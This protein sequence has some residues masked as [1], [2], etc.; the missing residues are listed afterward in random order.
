MD[1]FFELSNFLA[2]SLRCQA[3]IVSGR[4]YLSHIFQRLAAQ[5][6]TDFGQIPALGVAQ[7][8][9]PF[10][11]VPENGVF[12]LQILVSRHK[13]LVERKPTSVSNPCTKAN[14]ES[15][16]AI[17]V[18]IASKIAVNQLI[19]VFGPYEI[20]PLRAVGV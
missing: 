4:T 8:E 1:R 19:G 2:T 20:S 17:K 9:P 5:P 15:P 13:L 3:K 11:Q 7:T 14:Q 12:L 6:L 16:P 10:D 18:W